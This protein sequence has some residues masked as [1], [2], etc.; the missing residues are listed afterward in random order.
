M[1]I[2]LDFVIIL[3]QKNAMLEYLKIL[4]T[5]LIDMF[6]TPSIILENKQCQTQRLCP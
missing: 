1:S 6:S 3:T 5:K 2:N 4:E